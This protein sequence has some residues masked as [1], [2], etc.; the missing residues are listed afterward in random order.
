MGEG[1]GGGMGGS[2]VGRLVG[3]FER[4]LYCEDFLVSYFLN[5]CLYFNS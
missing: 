5:C 1:G 3:S 4:C 2:V